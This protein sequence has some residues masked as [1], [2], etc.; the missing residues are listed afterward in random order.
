MFVS[1]Q[2]RIV[3]HL[4]SCKTRGEAPDW[5]KT[6]HNV[7]LLKGKSKGIK[8][9]N[10]RPITCLPLMWK[11]LTVIVADEVQNH[12]GEDD[13]LPEEQKSCH[14]NSRGTKD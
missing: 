12:L 7:L 10:Y 13:I 14:R 3:F 4:Q 2:E 1:M 11:L 5:M 8:V 9:S 6:G